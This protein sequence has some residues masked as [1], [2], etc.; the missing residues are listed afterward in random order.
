[1]N[2]RKFVNF[3]C[4]GIGLM[5][6]VLVATK[7]AISDDKIHISQPIPITWPLILTYPEEVYSMTDAEFFV[8]ATKQNQKAQADGDAWHK[9]AAPKWI[10]YGTT[11]EFQ[12]ERRGRFFGSNREWGSYCTYEPRYLNP[13]YVARPLRIIN[14]YCKPARN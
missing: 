8:W 10:T 13:D 11:T 1:M 5:I 3:T 7:S 12:R 4:I 14:P 6:I 9:T 2:T